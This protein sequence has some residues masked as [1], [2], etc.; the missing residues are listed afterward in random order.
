[1]AGPLGWYPSAVDFDDSRVDV[2]GV[3]DRRGGGGGFGMPV[4][5]GGGGLGILGLVLYLVV[6]VLGGG[7]GG[8]TGV[9]LSGLQPGVLGD[10][11]RAGGESSER[12]SERCNAEGAI[13]RYDDCFVIKVWNEA[14]E[15]WAAEL[16]TATGASYAEPGLV[17]FSGA[18]RTGCGP[19]SSSVGPFYCPPDRSLFI[20]LDFLRQ[21]QTQFGAQGRYATAYIVAHEVGHHLQTLLGTEEQV[22]RAQ[23][24]RPDQQNALSVA[25]ELQ[26][27]CY[28]GVWGRQADERGNLSVTQAE[29]A[30]AQA[31]AAA[32]GDDRIQQRTSGRVDPESW[33]HGSAEAR[34]TWYTR[35]F[36]SGDPAV[37]DTFRA[38]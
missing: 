8:G 25:L 28:A 22:R 7:G 4:A 19:A 9:D 31:A 5:V 36:T 13:E 32:V 14:N 30:Q 33:T 3:S 26:A 6:G 29:L 12:L 10:G 34:R 17:F 18:T 2:S 24:A 11:A 21:L 37:C 23:Q 1:M 15:V 20:D 35:G 27:D 16:P 38:R